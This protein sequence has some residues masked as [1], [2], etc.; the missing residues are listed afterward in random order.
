MVQIDAV[1]N[2]ALDVVELEGTLAQPDRAAHGLLIEAVAVDDLAVLLGVL[3]VAAHGVD[4]Q[5]GLHD[6]GVSADALDL[7]HDGAHPLGTQIRAVAVVA[8][9]DLDADG[10]AGLD[11]V[12]QACVAQELDGLE[13]D[14]LAAVGGAVIHVINLGCHS[15]LSFSVIR[16]YI[17]LC[18][19]LIHEISDGGSGALHAVPLGHFH[20]NVV[21]L[22]VVDPDVADADHLL[23]EADLIAGDL[24]ETVDR[25]LGKLDVKRAEVIR[26]VRADAPADDGDDV[27]SLTE[28]PRQR[29]LRHRAADFF[30]RD[31]RLVHEGELALGGQRIGRAVEALLD[32]LLIAAEQAARETLID[33]DR[34]AEMVAHGD[35]LALDAAAEQ[36]VLEFMTENL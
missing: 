23:R 34:E 29:H 13:G 11:H 20:L 19:L 3:T 1:G 31:A 36:A 14:A 33:R 32:L 10:V 21:E 26:D 27:I 9:V 6:D 5:V 24:V 28:Q 17:G 12:L 35:D 2:L 30:R 18:F 15:S 7:F 4:V 16:I 25:R 22:A 8:G